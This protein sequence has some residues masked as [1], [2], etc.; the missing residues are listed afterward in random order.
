MKTHTT[1]ATILLSIGLLAGASLRAAEDILIADFEG[2]N[3]GDWKVTGEAFGPGPAR[4]TLP[5]QMR[6]EGFLGK[7]LV[8][9]FYNGDN[10]K[11]TLTSPEFTIR[12]PFISFLIGGGGWEGKTCMNLVVD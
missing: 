12:R 7:G 11:G 5:R 1:L 10:T 9:S 2:T 6:V 3:Y 8:N 4:G